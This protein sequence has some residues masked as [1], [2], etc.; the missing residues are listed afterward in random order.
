MRGWRTLRVRLVISSALLVAVACS[1]GEPATAVARYTAL[2]DSLIPQLERLSGLRA[3]G[4]V[5]VDIRTAAQVRAYLEQRMEQE[6]PAEA[7]AGMS[8]A[9]TMLGLLPDTLDL[10]ALLLE[11]YLEQVAGYYDPATKTMYVVEGIAA[12]Q[13]TV[14]AHELVHAL[15]DQNTNLDSLISR[16]RGNDR[17]TAAQAAMEGH[18]TL[19][20]IAAL[21]EHLT[22]RE[23]E[24]ASL[25]D[26]GA[27]LR[28]AL[29]S[30]EAY[31]VLRRAPR[32][33]REALIFPYV[34]GARFV[35]QLWKAR[36][37]GE[38]LQAPIGSLLPQSTEQVLQ[39]LERFVGAARDEP[40]ELRFEATAPAWPTLYENTLGAFE[41][42][43]FLQE[44]LGTTLVS[45]AGWDGDRYRVL[46]APQ[47]RALIWVIVWDDPASAARFAERV[48]DRISAGGLTRAAR[49]DAFEIEGRPAL[50]VTVA[51]AGVSLDAVPQPATFCAA[52]TGERT[53]C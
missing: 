44:L 41:T 22:D 28:P 26:P 48:R 42:G 27:D 13:R 37:S 6:M 5:Q 47:G 21:A 23:I 39:P 19:V 46:Q 50:R 52:M 7:I 53:R 1:R 9:Y 25:P 8:A 17:Q 24:P 33:V 43:L 4:P 36:P 14:M 31:P 35:Q 49:V 45:A 30:A 2:A 51:D 16:N 34:D 15:Q 18:A 32:V 3:R 10:R 40:T 12:D 29:E 20:M 11:L 38:P